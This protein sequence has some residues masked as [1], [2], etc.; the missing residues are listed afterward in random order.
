MNSR[1]SHILNML[2]EKDAPIKI[3]ELSNRFKMSERLVRYDLDN[4]DDFLMKNINKQLV[5]SRGKGIFCSLT[6]KE[7]DIISKLISKTETQA[8]IL[9]P[10]ERLIFILIE[11]F[12]TNHFVTTQ[13][14]CDLLMVSKSSVDKDIV[15]I[16]SYLKN[17]DL[18]LKTKAG[19]GIKV[20][21]DEKDIRKC[22]LFILH[23]H[24]TV[25]DLFEEENIINQSLF[26][27]SHKAKEL[28]DLEHLKVLVDIVKSSEEQMGKQF[29]DESFHQLVLQM[30]LTL[31]RIQLGKKIFLSDDEMKKL[32]KTKEFIVA[33][34]IT[35]LLESHTSV[36]YS[37][38]E[39]GYIA[40]FLRGVKESSPSPQDKEN[41]AEIQ[42]LT[43][44][45]IEEM[46]ERTNIP[47]TKDKDLF[48]G[49]YNHL[50][51][52]VFR[53]RNN[54]PVINPN[55]DLIK[56]NYWN[57]YEN[58]KKAL[59]IVENHIRKSI[60]ESEISYI[61]LHFCSSVER[62]RR[63]KM[64]FKVAIACGHG[65]G[66]AK[67]IEESLVSKF[68]N[69]DVKV[70]IARS[71]L[72]KLNVSQFDLIISTTKLNVENVPYIKVN[73]I[74][75]KSDYQNLENFFANNEPKN[76]SDTTEHSNLFKEI[77][78]IIERN[79]KIHSIQTLINELT[80]CFELNGLHFKREAVQPMLKDLLSENTV[81]FNVKVKDW[82]EAIQEG[83]NLLVD[84][85]CV[86]SKFVDEMIKTVE[87]MGPYIVI[88]PGVALPHA[89]PECGVKKLGISLITLEEPVNFGN[90][91]NDPVKVVICLGAV[92]SYSHLKALSKIVEIINDE[93]KLEMLKGAQN[94]EELLNVI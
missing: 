7:I 70:T 25:S 89:R 56:D 21:G 73:P 74:L 61:A 3:S 42:I 84:N 11:L 34:N 72:E 9:S 18:T 85:G 79:S 54:L 76:V 38:D 48:T 50:G 81:N 87:E 15:R 4:I 62:A 29:S 69:I 17:Y 59:V 71:H 41:W 19:K 78:Q 6:N 16:K 23:Q 33:L 66:A 10:D 80:K 55:L 45:L 26:S 94:F 68:H 93:K 39:I 13:Y 2:I 75:S 24:I 83:G 36:S 77:F 46:E 53:L 12:K 58:T 63:T 1:C 88:H 82:K 8:Y 28:I 14:F 35:N 92:D 22:I 47:F 90:E 40:H 60:S 20:E 31:K 64:K 37:I 49:L 91:D 52:T 44:R 86:E 27:L 65:I 51:S 30:G 57:I 43:L 5:R 32:K 67:L